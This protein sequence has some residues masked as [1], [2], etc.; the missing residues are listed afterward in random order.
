MI[1]CFVSLINGS[2]QTLLTPLHCYRHEV[3]CLTKEEFERWSKS[4]SLARQNSQAQS[5]LS[6]NLSFNE[7]PL[8]AVGGPTVSAASM[9]HDASDAT[10]NGVNNKALALMV[11]PSVDYGKLALSERA[12]LNKL[13]HS[14]VSN[15]APAEICL[16][17]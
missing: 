2:Q 10:Q 17:H 4:P 5:P 8:D 1:T 13:P 12:P 9:R 15:N 11:Q 6:R 7:G 16:S 14:S 3:N